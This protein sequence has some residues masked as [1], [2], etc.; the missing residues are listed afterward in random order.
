MQRSKTCLLL[1]GLLFVLPPGR[2]VSARQPNLRRVNDRWELTGTPLAIAWDAGTGAL[3]EVRLAAAGIRLLDRA[4]KPFDLHTDAGWLWEARTG[5]GKIPGGL[6]LDGLWRFNLPG[7][8]PRE[9]R[10]PGAWEK[11]G[12]TGALPDSPEPDWLPYNGTAWYR[13]TFDLPS[14]LRGHDL[15]L[16]IERVD[17]FD[18]VSI[19]GRAIGHTGQDTPEWWAAP[20]R[21]AVPAAL[22]KPAGNAIEIKVYDRGGEGGILGSVILVTPEREK[23]LRV[24]PIRLKRV[25]IEPPTGDSPISVVLEYAGGTWTARERWRVDRDR[26]F[27]SRTVELTLGPEAG[28]PRFDQ[29]YLFLGTL[30]ADL[31]ASRV[32]APYVW[33]PSR[34]TVAE[35]ATSGSIALSCATAMT[36]M[37]VTPVAE[38][39]SLTLG[40]YWEKDWNIWLAQGRRNAVELR[41]KYECL[42]RVRAGLTIPA[43][44]QFISV[45]KGGESEGLQALGTAWERLGFR[46][47]PMPDWNRGL[48]LYSLSAKGSMGSH[49]R[50]LLS[51]GGTPSALRNFQRLQ[52]P[53]LERLGITAIWFLPL[54]P[55]GYGVS[56]YW[57]VD[58]ATGTEDDLRAVVADAHKAG[59]RVLGDLIP[60]GPHASSGLGREHPE[61]VAR[62]EDGSF[63]SWWGCLACDYAHPGWQQYM[64]RVAAHWVK[65]CDLDGW[66]VDVAGGGQP[67]WKP[68]GGSLPSWSRQWGGLRIMEAVRRAVQ[69]VKP[70]CLL[71]G[72]CG[73]PPMLGQ[74][75]CIYDWSAERCMFQFLESD[76]AVWVRDFRAWLAR[77]RLALPTGAAQG[78]MHFTENHDQ[79]RSAWQ[80]GP[81]AARAVWALCVFAEG[82]PLIYHGQEVGF[83]DFWAE[84]LKTR[85]ALTELRSGAAD[86]TGVRTT[87]PR[88]LAF[89]R[90]SGPNATLVAVNFSGQVQKVRLSWVRPPR[91]Y[92]LAKVL[93]PGR[94]IPVRR[95]ENAGVAVDAV[96]PPWGWRAAALRP[97]RPSLAAVR[98]PPPLEPRP[99]RSSHSANTR[100]AVV[101]RIGA[102]RQGRTL[103][104]TPGATVVL[105]AEA[106]AGPVQVTVGDMDL[107]WRAGLIER[108]RVRGKPLL[109]G[110]T[111]REGAQRVFGGPMVRI[112]SL[113]GDTVTDAASVAR[114]TPRDGAVERLPGGGVR[115]TYASESEQ[116][117]FSTTIEIG[118]D[119]ALALDLR[120]TPKKPT[121]AVLG[122]LYA[123]F[124]A[125]SVRPGTPP[126]Q[127]WRV[128]TVEGTVGGPFAVR[129][130]T[131]AELAGRFWHPVQRL[132]EHSLLPLALER[133]RLEWQAGGHRLWIECRSYPNRNELSNIYLREYAPDG[134]PGLSAV[135]AGAD[136]RWAHEFSPDRPFRVRVRLSVDRE[137]AAQP[138][139]LP[140]RFRTEG[141]NW[142]IENQYYRVRIRRSRGG[143][144]RA[145][146]IAGQAQPVLTDGRT[147]TDYGILGQRRDPLG[148]AYRVAGTNDNDF[149]P[150]CWITPGNDRFELRFRGRMRQRGRERDL[151]QPRIEYETVWTFTDTPVIRVAQR[152]RP[153][154]PP[155][156]GIKAFLAPVFRLSGITGWRSGNPDGTTEYGAPDLDGSGRIW[157][158]GPLSHT[159]PAIQFSVGPQRIDFE[160]IEPW[161]APPQNIFLTRT[162][163]RNVY[164]LFFALLDGQPTQLDARW[165]GITYRINTEAKGP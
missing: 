1:G 60:H 28:T 16:V 106:V 148:N 124:C 88:V 91:S 87:A 125:P 157:V 38:R 109:R 48:A 90:T 78:L 101:A 43:G 98:P 133:P 22:L 11:Q 12:V 17:D 123:A 141:A 39:F 127:R 71:L 61:Y 42:G 36:G 65:I 122:R 112:S 33:P 139:A 120:L 50:D 66:R 37:T 110:M 8:K 149:E 158:F 81:D 152:A 32:V 107:T 46:R 69:Q 111:V 135:F 34:P 144:L 96:L 143:N 151:V 145:L 64:A 41:T 147:Y 44:G 100:H 29:M 57:S 126:V 115:L 85:S 136:A 160:H 95:I 7:G 128:S 150:D 6:I 119:A 99:V 14:E 159:G 164:T 104:D 137:P 55:R 76:P 72:E 27:A 40:Q 84:A 116:A 19:N 49:M 156:P 102:P 80:L 5:R 54:W 30:A 132:W 15:V 45:V 26:P 146:H 129:H 25:R 153:L 70:D 52:L 82:F 94:E 89:A 51:P 93:P 53:L 2:P 163:D 56:D 79:V 114:F 142:F 165:R 86:Y 31:N 20:R 35:F 73:N 97:D 131:S 9:I 130:P 138:I 118:R 140:V 113:Q 77:E 47:P 121:G 67:N 58:P 23:E 155:E 161:G 75:Q 13:R 108:L 92:A 83:E 74:A 117:V 21:Y 134:K 24:P 18:W 10:V 62:H 68:I 63:I 103:P 154:V 4:E 3:R 105:R 59:V 162:R